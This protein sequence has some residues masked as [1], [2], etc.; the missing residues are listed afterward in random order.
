MD[1]MAAATM[2]TNKKISS[3]D[4]KNRCIVHQGG[5][6]QIRVRHAINKQMSV[7]PN[8]IQTKLNNGETD[9][10]H[11]HTLSAAQHRL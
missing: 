6:N 1:D 8:G 7:N 4:G 11:P 2:A 10:S 3:P 9:N 5:N